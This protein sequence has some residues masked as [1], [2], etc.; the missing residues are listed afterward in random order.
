MCCHTVED[1]YVAQR[2]INSEVSLTE[3]WSDEHLG[4]NTISKESY[5]MALLYAQEEWALDWLDRA[6]VSE[7][8]LLHFATH[9]AREPANFVQRLAKEGRIPDLQEWL[10]VENRL[11]L[12][13]MLASGDITSY[14]TSLEA[15]LCDDSIQVR[16]AVEKL[17]ESQN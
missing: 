13:E 5:G 7:L 10:T 1:A 9:E 17:L 3:R 14:R 12:L 6:G 15:F 11:K 2:I 8:M 4:H 16:R